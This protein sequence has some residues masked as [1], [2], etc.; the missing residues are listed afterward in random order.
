MNPEISPEERELDVLLDSIYMSLKE[1]SKGEDI[2]LSIC[3]SLR[4]I[5]SRSLF[6]APKDDEGE[7]QF[8]TYEQFTSWAARELRRRLREECDESQLKTEYKRINEKEEGQ[9]ERFQA[10]VDLDERKSQK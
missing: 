8:S 10:K 9:N 4:Q 5:Q 6:K 3:D 2:D 1:H 7:E